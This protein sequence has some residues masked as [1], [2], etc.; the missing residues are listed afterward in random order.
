MFKG[1][2]DFNGQSFRVRWEIVFPVLFFVFISILILSSTSTNDVFMQSTF[3]KQVIW[4]FIGAIAFYLVQFVRIQYL[5]DYSYLFYLL[6]FIL[7]GITILF[8]PK[9]AGS[10]RWIVFG[11]VY[12]QPSEIGKII[13]II[14]IARFL[15]DFK[16]KDR[17]TKNFIFMLPVLVFPPL[18]VFIQPDLGTA[19]IYL[20][21][22]IPMI[23]WSGFSPMII[24]ILIAPFISLLAVSNLLYFYIWMVLFVLLMF[25][26]RPSLFVII[27]NFILN[28]ICGLFSPYVWENILKPHQR[29]RI[30]T[31]LDP[32]S[33]PLGAGYQVIQS[34]ISIGSGGIW[35]KGWGNGTQTQLKF[36]P[37]RDTDF[38]ISVI[39]EELGFITIFFILLFLM[40]F[41]YWSFEYANKIENKFASLLL[42]GCATII[43]MHFFINMGMVS[44][45]F[46]VTGLPVPF[47]SYGGSFFI[48][49][50]IILG[51]INN[52]INNYI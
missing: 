8:S 37:V 38:I 5:Y 17:L 39:G 47:I 4:F 35:G 1:I 46:P 19:M 32:F 12:F 28:V 36:L 50:S 40:Y 22:I 3:Y 15:T 27:F 42:A 51:I 21:V 44:G 10:K 43:F 13:Y 2:F 9:I 41:V 52:I 45:L 18:L 23:F 33:D 34:I 29:Q 16:N 31:F 24:F 26:Y 7:I 20:S 14:F 30:E 48:S 25:Y 49:C 6:L 11:P